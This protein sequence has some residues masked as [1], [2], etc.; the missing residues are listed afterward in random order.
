MNQQVTLPPIKHVFQSLLNSKPADPLHQKNH[1]RRSSASMESA[2]EAARS[3]QQL[4]S[5]SAG[6]PCFR[7]SPGPAA[8]SSSYSCCTASHQHQQQP[9]HTR[10]A[11]SFGGHRRTVS[12]SVEAPYHRHHPQHHVSYPLPPPPAAA[13]GSMSDTCAPYSHHPHSHPHYQH[14]YYAPYAHA[15]AHQQQPPA[16]YFPRRARAHTTS[17][18]PPTMLYPMHA[19]QQTSSA[20]HSTTNKMQIPFSPPSSSSLPAS[21]S[22]STTTA[23][24]SSAVNHRYHCHHCRK[25]FS[26]PSSLRIH[27]YSHTGEKPFKCHYQGCGRSFSVHSNMRRHL[28]VHYYPQ[29][30]QQQTGSNAHMNSSMR[31]PL[32]PSSRNAGYSDEDEEGEEDEEQEHKQHL[33]LMRQQ[34]DYNKQQQTMCYTNV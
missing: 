5:A 18:Y 12:A 25:S 14:R 8:P 32:V 4:S 31:L 19:N 30:L 1:H 22:A 13:A 11:A 6:A 26:R 20:A 7:C 34:T 21:A 15:H 16:H 24:N 27:I 33:M 9:A 3:L 17:G 23:K 10:F 2:V 28:R 29:P